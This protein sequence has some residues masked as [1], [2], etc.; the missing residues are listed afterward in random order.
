MVLYQIYPQSGYLSFDGETR[1]RSNNNVEDFETGKYLK[2]P[3][4]VL[5]GAFATRTCLRS[6]FLVEVRGS[7]FTPDV[8]TIWIP[9]L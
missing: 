7:D 3:Y 9:L 8:S 5:V 2:G 1:G 4:K 6:L